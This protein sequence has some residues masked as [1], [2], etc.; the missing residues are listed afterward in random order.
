MEN[1]LVRSVRR[2]PNHALTH[3]RP[4]QVPDVRQ[5]DVRRSSMNLGVLPAALR[6]DVRGDS[7]VDCNVVL[8]G[9]GF[10]A[11]TA[12]NEEAVSR[13]QFVG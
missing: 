2:A 1:L 8:A 4:T 11:E 9:V 6:R 13:V 7:S 3:R 10:H 5:Y 12:D